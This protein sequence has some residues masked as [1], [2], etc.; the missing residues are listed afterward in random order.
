MN[1]ILFR[2]IFLIID[3]KVMSSNNKEEN[4]MLKAIVKG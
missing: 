3:K 1:R 4:L 2:G